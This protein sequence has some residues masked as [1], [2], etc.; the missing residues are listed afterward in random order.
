M[1]APNL[2]SNVNNLKC[3]QNAEFAL[4]MM[5]TIYDY[6]RKT[7]QILVRTFIIIIAW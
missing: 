2:Q 6:S 3:I 1:H 7:P 5:L 4:K